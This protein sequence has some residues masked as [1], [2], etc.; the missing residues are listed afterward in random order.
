MSKI[1]NIV[2]VFIIFTT[3][4]T[5]QKNYENLKRRS[6]IHIRAE[7]YGE[8]IDQ[9]NKYISANARDAE[10]Y[11]LR[12]ICYENREQYDYAVYDLRIAVRLEPGNSEYRNNLNRIIN[13]WYPILY[14][15]IEGYKRE[16]A[17]DPAN[18][19]N[20][21]EIG[22]CY[23]NLE[24]WKNA[25]L[26]Y[27]KYL[28]RDNDASPDEIIRYSIILEKNRHIRKG[29][30]I[31]KE[32]VERYPEDWRLWSRYGYF[33]LW[34]GKYK[35][36]ED[37]FSNALAFKPYFKEALDGL[38]LARKEG[39]LIQLQ[40]DNSGRK[41][42][43]IDRLYWLIKK[44]PE[45]IDY[46]F[47]LIS[48]LIKVNRLQEALNQFK[49]LEAH[50]SEDENYTS[51]IENTGSIIDSIRNKRIELFTTE[52]KEDPTNE[53][54]VIK[55]A[56]EYAHSFDYEAALEILKEYM[57]GNENS[58][59]DI[60]R[61]RFAQY[62]AWNY[63]F[64]NA[65]EQLD[66][67]LEKDAENLDYRLLRGQ[68]AVWVVGDFDLAEKYL[69][70]VH[71]ARPKN[72]TAITTLV[73]LY[74]WKRNFEKANEYLNLAKSIDE[75]SDLVIASEEAYLKHLNQA[76]FEEIFAIRVEAQNLAL[77]KEF[78]A[79]KEKYDEYFEQIDEP[80]KSEY[81]EYTDVLNALEEYDESIE[82]YKNILEVDDDLSVKRRMAMSYIWIK[83]S[84]MALSTIHEIKSEMESDDDE[85]FIVNLLYAKALQLDGKPE[86][87]E[88]LLDSAKMKMRDS[89]E[90]KLIDDSKFK[91]D[92]FIG[93]VYASIEEYG[94]AEDIYNSMIEE[95]SDSSEIKIV[96]QRIDWLPEY[97][98]GAGASSLLNVLLPYH[99]GLSPFG[100]FYKDNQDFL[101]WSAGSALD[102]GLNKFIGVGGSFT[103]YYFYSDY[104]AGNYNTK[105]I[106]RLLGNVNLFWHKYFTT[107]ISYGIL[108]S[109]DIDEKETW[110]L[111]LN[112]VNKF[113]A[114]F[115]Y[116]KTDART[117]LYSPKIL[118][119]DFDAEMYQMNIEYDKKNK[120]HL[121]LLYK[122][123][124]LTDNNKG[125]DLRFRFG[126]RFVDY[127]LIGYEYYFIDF[128]RIDPLY[129]SPQDFSSHSIW[130]KADV[131]NEDNLDINLGGKFGYAPSVDYVLSEINGEIDYN[132]YKFLKISG[133]ASIGR[134]FRYDSAYT[135]ISLYVSAY[136]SIY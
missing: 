28:A 98:F 109:T 52:L 39:Y 71:E 105:E 116:N 115:S 135:Y 3:V 60:V 101:T 37:A 110:G 95:T 27:D 90:L 10:G 58:F 87:A 40:I 11:N 23:K 69:L 94:E 50:H 104:Y 26:W 15:K 13:I 9:L 30:K 47:D 85:L 130:A 19:F 53:D 93:D 118:F 22:K 81:I 82:I 92:L 100:S 77:E 56:E 34:L 80:T 16:I 12:G 106:N 44:Y 112:Y 124:T 33:T 134:S 119:K 102:I 120:M 32:W 76:K 65:I 24:E 48:E 72:I 70:S 43:P 126:K 136:M 51:K 123:Y 6:M 91:T 74:A 46:R 61:F 31:L 18:P 7:R 2:F 88:E 62:S 75:N 111:S 63:D 117:I 122:Y 125:N 42:Y 79:S 67:L 17:I 64:E 89:D 133:E 127:S 57:N 73:Q 29:E 107:N 96:K 121:S 8:A 49:Y 78:E 36:A 128:G 41:V 66:I 84:E 20:Y 132:P 21:L 108:N 55:L 103:H 68:I 97:G 114:S 113:S 38:D 1:L 83:D 25:E 5:A 14:K 86:E 129:Y 35:I 59:S 4:L 131:Y 99:M 45:K 54:S